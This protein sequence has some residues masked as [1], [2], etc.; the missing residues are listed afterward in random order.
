MRLSSLAALLLAPAATPQIAAQAIPAEFELGY[1]FVDVSGNDGMYRTQINDRPGVLLRS[2]DW[3][4][5]AP[6]DG[7]LDYFRIDASDVGAGPAGALRVTGGQVDTF[8]L[9]FSWRRTNL[10][11]D[12][13]A[14]ANPFLDDGIVPGQH[15]YNRT[16][17]IYDAT[18]QILPGKM[19]TPILGY[20]RNIYRGPGRTTYHVG[21][22]DFALDDEMLA[23][24]DEYRI[25]LQF[26]AGPVQGAVIQGWRRYRFSDAVTL[27][28]GAD[29]GNVSFPIL[30]RLVTADEIDRTTTGKTNTPTTSAWV[31]A[32]P[33]ARVKL[34]GS[35]V[36]ANGSTEASSA[37][38][39][40]G[41]FVSFE[42]ARFFAG[43]DDSIV[44]QARTHYWRGSARAE[45]QLAP[46]VD[47]TGGWTEKSRELTG[48]ALASSLYLDAVTYGGISVGN[49]LQIVESDTSLDRDDRTFDASVTVRSL[50]PFAV[51]GGW[52]GTHQD[53]KFGG[54]L[55]SLIAADEGQTELTRTVNTYGGG[56]SFSR[57]G[58]TLGGDYR[59]DSAD[60]PI[61]RS[62]FVDRDRYK[63]R[64]GWSWKD[65]VRLGATYQETH[66]D[67]DAAEIGYRAVVR[68]LAADAS[69]S[70]W[71]NAV[72]LHAS[73]GQF[74]TARSILIR[75]PQDFEIA[76]TDQRELGH[77]WEG[78]VTLAWLGATLDGSYL[79]MNNDGS[80]PFTV[81]RARVRAEYFF[82]PHVGLEGE[83]TRDQYE[84]RAAL[85]QAGPLANFNANRYGVFLHWRP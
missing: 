82:T 57:A 69:V 63:F 22:N 34:I 65:W 13:P 72:T 84:E 3:A 36:R 5:T 52:S 48:S 27:A 41:S 61:L 10:F 24:D 85:D 19:F 81:Q 76:P 70:L 1:R 18:L 38:T 67:D 80:I 74:K 58:V 26:D 78:G 51:N 20:T 37:E 68:E 73:G 29:G 46:D 79:W 62:D 12:L 39:D 6:L 83:W 42:L 2:L 30:G 23:I 56:F 21:Q 47:L 33:L 32:R 40:A 49:L 71:K 15:T 9:D 4:S 16:R 28:P 44:A 60:R 35:Y 55:S 7:V 53:V 11:S 54:D 59:H 25:G 77:T 50:G 75:Q 43:L 8:R 64:A 31:T 66:A 45:V 17:D 14:F